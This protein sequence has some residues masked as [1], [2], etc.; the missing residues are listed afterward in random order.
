FHPLVDT[1]S[2]DR[3]Y[4]DI[5][6][7]LDY[8]FNSTT[9]NVVRYGWI[10]SR[11]FLPGLSPSASA[12]SLALAG[13][14]TSAGAIALAPG[15]AQTEFLDVPIDVDTQ[16]ARTQGN[17]QRNTHLVDAFTKIVGKHNFSLGGDMR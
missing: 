17:F 3:R 15:L 12:T 9:N 8:S 1:T 6:S 4:D 10:R 11:N 13:A 2:N 5:I 7:T 16:R 14:S